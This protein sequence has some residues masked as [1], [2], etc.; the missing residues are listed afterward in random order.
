MF[1]DEVFPDLLGAMLF[2]PHPNYIA[3]AAVQP[4][5][6]WDASKR[7]GDTIQLDRY[8]FWSE[9]GLTKD[10]RRRSKTET[11]GTANSEDI[12]KEVVNLVLQEYTGPSTSS[13]QASTFKIALQDAL[14]AQRRLFDT[15]NMQA[16]HD[17]IGSTRLLDDYKRWRDRVIINELAATSVAYNP[18]GVTDAEVGTGT[19]DLDNTKFDITTDLVTVVE[20]LRNKNIPPFPDGTYHCICSPRFMKHLRQDS[21]FRQTW[22]QSAQ[23]ANLITGPGPLLGQ[24]G[25][26][27]PINPISP[28]V[29]YEGVLFFESTNVPTLSVTT[30]V[31][32]GDIAYPAYFFGMQSVGIAT[33]G[34]GP[35][36]LVN[37]DDD[38]GRFIILIWQMY[39]DFQLLNEDFVVEARTYAD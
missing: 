19:N 30:D 25:P 3:E 5:L 22:Q 4:V 18:N 39:G 10:A 15:G 7:P 23:I 16:F 2:E 33:G 26:M 37:Q 31:G 8:E 17:S 20:M 27:G 32:A 13:G 12:D 9:R 1:I 29:M 14:Y 24:M 11:L 28:P 6:V 38:F 36:I 35:R 34:M 21:D